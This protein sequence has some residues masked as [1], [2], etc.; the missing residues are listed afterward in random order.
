MKFENIFIHRSTRRGLTLPAVY[1]TTLI[2]LFS[3]SGCRSGTGSKITGHCK[4]DSDCPGS[5][6][7]AQKG[8]SFGKCVE[9]D[10]DSQCPTGQACSKYNKCVQKT[11]EPDE[12][13]ESPHDAD[14]LDEIFK[15]RDGGEQAPDSPDRGVTIPDARDQDFN[16][17]IEENIDG[18]WPD[19]EP[20][21]CVPACAG[22]CPGAYDGCNGSC[23]ENLCP[24]CCKGTE[25]IT[26]MNMDL[27]HCGPAGS[28]CLDCS[29]VYGNRAD[30]CLDGT[31]SCGTGKNICDAGWS[32]KQGEC[33]PGCT[34]DCTG[35]CSGADDNCGGNCP[36]SDCPNICCD[37]QCCDAGQ[38]CYAG[39]C[40][41][42]R[43][44]FEFGFECGLR[45][46][47]CGGT[48]D[49]GTCPVNSHCSNNGKCNCD[50]VECN[51]TCCNKGEVC[52]NGSCCMPKT[53]NEL[54]F[55]CGSHDNGCGNTLSCGNCPASFECGQ[56]GKCNLHSTCHG[57][58]LQGGT[59]FGFDYAPQGHLA[60]WVGSDYS[61]S[62][63]DFERDLGAMASMGTRVVRIM[64]P[65]YTLGLKMQQNSG[66]GN[67]DQAEL[68]AVKVNL[69]AVIERF[70]DYGISVIIA[71]GPNAYWWNGPDQNTKWWEWIYGPG[72]WSDLVSDLVFWSTKIVEFVETSSSCSN[73][74]YYDL[75]NEVDYNVVGMHELVQAQLREIPVPDFKRG[76]SLL[77]SEKI[78]QLKQDMATTGK[79]LAFVDFHSYPDRGLHSDVP[80]TA[81]LFRTAFPG[82]TVLLGEFGAIFCENGQDED[83][84]SSTVSSI[85]SQAVSA[86]LPVALNWMLWDRTSGTA[87]GQGDERIGLGYGRDA[88]RDVFGALTSRNSLVP[89]PDFEE[90]NSEWYTGGQNQVPA[91]IIGTG[92]GDSATN[93]HYGRMMV[94]SP[95]LVWLCSN[96]APLG[97]GNKIAV[98]GYVRSNISELHMDVH[99][100]KDQVEIRTLSEGFTTT[101]D[102]KWREIQGLMGGF[103]FDIPQGA[104]RFFVCGV[105]TAPNGTNSS[106]PV[107]LDMDAVSANT[108]F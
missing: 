104:N 75:Q 3:W 4:V 83:E 88:P 20:E 12:P 95:G 37:K 36:A 94:T 49:C 42:P 81:N 78:D 54:G 25:C 23:D 77:R 71:F 27:N 51:N 11:L 38:T 72:N 15:E 63:A 64:L 6:I 100:L 58:S 107:Y 40:C 46:D 44:C 73:V 108:F 9:C 19:N 48:Q 89:D 45:I 13:G 39:S 28:T 10:S 87:C 59:S 79:S 18:D 101:L 60:K 99:F 74:L 65:P 68:D 17:E 16:K 1:F 103:A 56:D 21:Q 24:G 33:K 30:T 35:K 26:N 31:C 85:L 90:Q 67:I 106:S 14:L 34:P 98:D 62:L 50:N 105:L 53:C 2:S 102:W 57:P 8:A 61:A 41:T 29:I 47:G 82:A 96:V 69:P 7:C 76:L 22:K 52:F 32:C 86:N 92:D 84:Q 43:T 97:Q 70:R 80:A 66:P 5:L 91:F 93:D 55:E